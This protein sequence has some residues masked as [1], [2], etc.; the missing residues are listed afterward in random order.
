MA[1]TGDAVSLQG[2]E[3]LAAPLRLVADPVGSSFLLIGGA[4]TDAAYAR[5][6]SSPTAAAASRFVTNEVLRVRKNQE[7][8][9]SIDDWLGDDE[10]LDQWTKNLLSR[11]EARMEPAHGVSA[12]QLEIYAPDVARD[13]N[14]RSRW[15]P[16]GQIYQELKET[17]LCRP[18]QGFARS[19]DRP[20]ML[21][22]F[23]LS[24]GRLT[25][26]RSTALDRKHQYRLSFGFD[27][28]LGTQRRLVLTVSQTQFS[29]DRPLWLPEP[30]RRVYA[31]GWD[32]P[33]PGVNP[34]RLLFGINSLPFVLHALTRLNVRPIITNRETR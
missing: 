15:L 16:A 6:A 9:C 10:P 7:L 2:G 5:L 28:R 19:Y 29:V 11:H 14:R 12:D 30:E 23:S 8:V 21:A 25:I 13:T 27:L 1:M 26:R 18:L 33:Q 22:Q 17:R 31:L 34:E 3:W 32:A 20:S 4:P 24:D